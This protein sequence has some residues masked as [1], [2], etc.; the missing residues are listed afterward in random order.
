MGRDY[1]FVSPCNWHE[2][3]IH[4]HIPWLGFVQVVALTIVLMHYN[5]GFAVHEQKHSFESGE[6]CKVHLFI[7]Y[8][9]YL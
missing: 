1:Q 6:V 7:M 4:I 8:L 3:W 9:C 5:L 2:A